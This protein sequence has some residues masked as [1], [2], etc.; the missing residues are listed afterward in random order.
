VPTT[1]VKRAR[2]NA[3]LLMSF[4]TGAGQR[5]IKRLGMRIAPG[6]PGRLLVI[7]VFTNPS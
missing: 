5:F 6:I 7:M 2:S 1:M 4:L 3:A